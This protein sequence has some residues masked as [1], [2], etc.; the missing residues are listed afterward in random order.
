MNPGAGEQFLL[1]IRHP[2]CY[3]YIQSSPVKVQADY[4]PCL[5]SQLTHLIIFKYVY[6]ILVDNIAKILPCDKS[7]NFVQTNI[8]SCLFHSVSQEWFKRAVKA[9]LLTAS[10]MLLHAFPSMVVSSLREFPENCVYKHGELKCFIEY[11]HRKL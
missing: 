6:H 1:L 3:S 11:L 5:L 2:P 7:L 10:G 8:K 9:S 4:F